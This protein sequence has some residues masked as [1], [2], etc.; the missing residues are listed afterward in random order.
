V[1]VA[2]LSHLRVVD[3]TDLRGALSGRMLSDLGAEVI[4]IERRGH[5]A[6]RLTPPFAG[7]VAAPD[8]SLPF[9]F[10]NLGKGAVVL[11]LDIPPAGRG[12]W[13]SA[14]GPTS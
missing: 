3:L 1:S 12:S 4:R 2:A 5:D 6:D 8:R 10:R 14:T 7:E 9:L 11:D 13:R